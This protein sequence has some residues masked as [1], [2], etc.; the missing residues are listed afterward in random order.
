MPLL[1]GHFTA[2]GFSLGL[3]IGYVI[4]IA[5]I[6][7]GVYFINREFAIDF[8][9]MLQRRDKKGDSD[10]AK[11]KKAVAEMVDAEAAKSA[12]ANGQ[13]KVRF[14]MNVF[15]FIVFALILAYYAGFKDIFS[16]GGNLGLG[17]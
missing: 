8:S 9:T 5:I 2:L 1:V 3:V 16:L 11:A 12:A 14:T 4:L 13:G 10:R 15:I 7:V 17:A 6:A